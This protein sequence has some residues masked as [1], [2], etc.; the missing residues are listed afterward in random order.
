[1][2]SNAWRD[3]NAILRK[4][5]VAVS[6]FFEKR[7]RWSLRADYKDILQGSCRRDCLFWRGKT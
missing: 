5:V 7:R 3:R 4:R 1:M 2:Q 6:N